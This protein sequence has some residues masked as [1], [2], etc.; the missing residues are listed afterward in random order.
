MK[1]KFFFIIIVLFLSSI[2]YH[3]S[4]KIAFS[5]AILP[6][7]VAPARQEVALEPGES[8]TLNVRFYNLGESPVVGTVK[9]VDFI[10]ENNLGTPTF[11]EEKQEISPKYSASLWTTLPYDRM[12][13][14]AYDKVSVP[15]SISVPKNVKPGGRYISVYFEAVPNLPP[16]T[17]SSKETGTA[18]TP[19]IAALIS[20]RVKGDAFEKA[21]IE[22]F[23]ARSFYEYGP[24]PVE[25]AILNRGDY[26]VKPQGVLLVTNIFGNLVAQEKLKEQNIFPDTSRT[27]MNL[28]GT[29]WMLGKYKIELGASYGDKGQALN[30]ILYVWVF[31]WRV[32]VFVILTFFII[33]ILTKSFFDRM[34]NKTSVLEEEL[35]EEKA[36]IEKLREALKKR[37]D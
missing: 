31:P 24:I 19:R 10:V 12:S 8:T 35:E 17:R 15:V 9:T 30:R 6:L 34:N 7:T 11:L 27:Y 4:S 21:L 22:R 13:I 25:T 26:H 32:A 14:A 1:N 16:N 37:S 29:K 28:L 5:Q 20:I 23:F 36:E 18:V 2:I 3:L 33:F